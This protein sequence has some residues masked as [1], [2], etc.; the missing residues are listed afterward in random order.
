MK[1]SHMSTPN[2]HLITYQSHK[3]FVFDN[4]SCNVA[5]DLHDSLEEANMTGQ[6]GVQRICVQN[7]DY[8]EL[9]AKTVT[10]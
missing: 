9:S 10:Y 2:D 5:L 8:V 7:A 3:L 4:R 1:I 6:R